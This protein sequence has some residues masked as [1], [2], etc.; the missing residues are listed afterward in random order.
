MNPPF[1]IHYL[2]Q[3]KSLT[4]DYIL[5][6]LGA[7]C[8][9]V[10]VK[11]INVWKTNNRK[12]QVNSKAAKF[13]YYIHVFPCSLLNLIE[14]YS[15][16]NVLAVFLGAF[17]FILVSFCI[18]VL[19]WI[20]LFPWWQLVDWRFSFCLILLSISKGSID[21]G[22]MNNTCPD[23][24]QAQF[25]NVSIQHES[26]ATATICPGTVFDVCTDKTLFN[27]TY[28]ATCATTAETKT[29][30]GASDR[31]RYVYIEYPMEQCIW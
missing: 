18:T 19:T 12:V 8:A 24:L 1:L 7:K 21:D 22:S 6:F 13:K 4:S 5:I 2:L 26:E 20:F 3:R 30:S 14:K 11:M 25:G 27:I 23:E 31:I 15:L 29:L 17:N 16:R 10:K 9:F 28:N